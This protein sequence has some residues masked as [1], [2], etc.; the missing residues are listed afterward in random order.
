ML[1]GVTQLAVLNWTPI[2]TNTT[3]PSSGGRKLRE[4]ENL[5]GFI[6]GILIATTISDLIKSRIKSIGV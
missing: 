3:A 5:D 2:L 6:L 1:T 4:L